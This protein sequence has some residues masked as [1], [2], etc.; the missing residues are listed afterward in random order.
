M[1]KSHALKILCTVMLAAASLPVFGQ[2]IDSLVWQGISRSYQL[3]L[4]NGYDRS[5]RYPLIVACHPGLSNAAQ[6]A[7]SARW[8]VLGDTAGF[9]T[10]YPNGMPSA[11]NANSRLWNAYDQPSTVREYDDV[12][13]LNVLLDRL[14]SNYSVD[15][16]RVYMSGFSNGAM[17]TYRMACDLTDR[18]AAMAPLSG[19]WGYGS[20]GSCGDGNCNGDVAPGCSWRMAYVNCRPTRPIPMIFMK[21]SL[22]GDNLPTCRGTIDSLNRFYWSN[23]LSCGNSV[24][25]TVRVAGELVV[26]EHFA[27]CQ[28]DFRFYTVLGNSHQ[29]HAPATEMF[30]SFLRQQTKCGTVSV[31]SDEHTVDEVRVYPNPVSGGKFTIDVAA[32]E[33]FNVSLIDVFGRTY[34]C[35]RNVNEIDVTGLAPGTYIV[36]IERGRNTLRRS[37]IVN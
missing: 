15:T 20:D 11:S 23:N 2:A 5:K 33:D 18:F 12:G 16:C 17:M 19:G 1:N 29:W 34:L 21:G 13:F 37:V 3:H 9:I 32:D 28:K 26:R 24:I 14:I 10:V 35:A 4:P 8:H 6:H 22:E 36:V 7:E 27:G 25:D 30:W 31:N